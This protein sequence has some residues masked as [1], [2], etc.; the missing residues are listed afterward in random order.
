[1]LLV[2]SG[3][4]PLNSSPNGGVTVPQ[5]RLV[6]ERLNVLEMET[7]VHF[8]SASAILGGRVWI[9]LSQ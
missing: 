9:V 2:E 4:A 8:L 5:R 1:M 7:V 3:A 6:R